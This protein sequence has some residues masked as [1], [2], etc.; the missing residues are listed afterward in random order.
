MLPWLL[1]AGAAVLAALNAR[2]TFRLWRSAAFEQPQKVAQT[3]L[4]WVVPGTF[5]LV[6]Y[7]LSDAEGRDGSTRRL[8]NDDPTAPRP[9]SFDDGGL[10]RHDAGPSDFHD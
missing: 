2:T 3:V 4:L 6:T 8:A 9:E 1:L 5:A 10:H 7:L